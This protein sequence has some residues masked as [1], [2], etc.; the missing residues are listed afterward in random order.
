MKNSELD[1]KRESDESEDFSGHEGSKSCNFLIY[2]CRI[3]GKLT[4]FIRTL[5]GFKPRN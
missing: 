5:K 2:F 4:V 1:E 3:L